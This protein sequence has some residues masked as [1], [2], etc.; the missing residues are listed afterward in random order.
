MYFSGVRLWQDL[1]GATSTIELWQHEVWQHDRLDAASEA[2]VHTTATAG[3]P[4][5]APVVATAN[6][7]TA[8][9]RLFLWLFAQ[10]LAA[11]I[12]LCSPSVCLALPLCKTWSSSLAGESSQA[13]CQSVELL[14]AW[15]RDD[16]CES[17]AG[18]GA[19][20]SGAQLSARPTAQR[21]STASSSGQAPPTPLLLLLPPVS[22]FSSLLG[23][24]LPS[25]FYACLLCVLLS[26][27]VRPGPVAQRDAQSIESH[28]GWIRDNWC[29]SVAGGDA[30]ASCA[31]RP[32]TT[33]TVWRSSASK[34]RAA[35]QTLNAENSHRWMPR[36]TWEA[37]RRT[38]LALET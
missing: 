13:G 32:S 1:A 9:E 20:A 24:L 35:H 15:I 14:C 38:C 5:S 23:L 8:N 19:G 21:T 30:G 26:R 37:T 29:V 28:H 10:S 3:A 18:D 22:V 11:I 4:S 2:Q 7:A 17:V 36:R 16:L 25:T 27:S 34:C 6:A 33:H 12:L 31:Q